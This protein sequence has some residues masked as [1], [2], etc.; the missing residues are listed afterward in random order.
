MA[1]SANSI[2]T[3]SGTHHADEALAVFML[4]KLPQY[5]SMPL[6]RTRD[7][8]LID[9][10]SIVVDVG[11][12]YDPL[13]H[14]YD[15]HQRGFE[16]TFDAQHSIKL[17]SAGLVWKHF[18]TKILAEHLK[19][20]VDDSRVTLLHLKLYDDF[21][22]AIDAIDNGIAQYPSSAGQPLYKSKTDLSSRVGHTNPRWNETSS[23]ED[24]NARFERASTMAGTEFFD[25]VNYTFEAWLP[26]REIVLNALNVRKSVSGGDPQGRVLVFDEFASWKDHIFQLESDLAIPQAERALYVVYPDESGKWRIQAVPINPDSFVSRKPLPEPWRGVRDDALTKLTGIEGCIFVHQSGFIGGNATK[27][28]ALEMARQAVATV[29]PPSPLTSPVFPAGSRPIVLLGP[30]NVVAPLPTP[31]SSVNFSESAAVAGGGEGISSPNTRAAPLPSDLQSAKTPSVRHR[32]LSLPHPST[33]APTYFVL[34]QREKAASSSSTSGGDTSMSGLAE[35]NLDPYARMDGLLE[36]HVIRPENVERSWFVGSTGA[37]HAPVPGSERAKEMQRQEREELEE[38]E[39]RML[40]EAEALAKSEAVLLVKKEEKEQQEASAMD[41]DDAGEDENTKETHIG[42]VTNGVSAADVKPSKVSSLTRSQSARRRKPE[43]AGQVVSDGAVHML[44][45]VD[46]VFLLIPLLSLTAPTDTS[47]LGRFQPADDVFDDVAMAA[48]RRLAHK[49]NERVLSLL[50]PD[51]K[52][53]KNGSKGKQRQMNE[54]ERTAEGTELLEEEGV[55]MDIYQFGASR[56]GLEALARVCDVQALGNDSNVYRFNRSKALSVLVDKVAKIANQSVFASAPTTL[57]RTYAR[58]L[59]KLGD[60]EPARPS[61]GADEGMEVDG[62]QEGNPDGSGR[63][64]AGESV[65]SREERV[66]LQVCVGAV[67]A[68][69]D[70]DWRTKLEEEAIAKL[71]RVTTTSSASASSS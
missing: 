50:K 53:S 34:Y 18:G 66:R 26:A 68:W 38:E 64:D 19:L 55:W 21:V 14:R 22:Q 3:H 57:G 23:P 51:P 62:A 56:A 30:S 45:P 25:R 29:V 42:A 60:D 39:R 20:P 70:A 8:A 41:V 1:A 7:P 43:F 61:G 35:L 15:H 48:F 71:G 63:V 6:V 16:E 65:L 36:L 17:S 49:H 4:R 58:T 9:Q 13:R 24:Q 69:L 11:A 12:E 46:P 31:D 40:A 54:D 28:G 59:A 2:V 27:E 37:I 5:Q 67:S 47:D 10:G 33:G 32:F 52:K 44:V